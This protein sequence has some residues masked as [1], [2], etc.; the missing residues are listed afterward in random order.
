MMQGTQFVLI[1]T[2]N[3][4]LDLEGHGDILFG[5]SSCGCRF[6]YQMNYL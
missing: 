3:L 6:T 1:C 2:I 4:T 5:V